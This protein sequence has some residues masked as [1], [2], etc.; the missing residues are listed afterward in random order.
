MFEEFSVGLNASPGASV[1]FAVVLGDTQDGFKTKK[2]YLSFRIQLQPGP[3]Y[4]FSK[5]PILGPE[6]P[7]PK[8]CSVI[9]ESELQYT[10]YF[11]LTWK[12]I[13]RNVCIIKAHDKSWKVWRFNC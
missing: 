10:S 13:Y 7:D 5:I 1:Y 9:V 11:Y 12:V 3:G 4:G 6:N 8:L 2:G